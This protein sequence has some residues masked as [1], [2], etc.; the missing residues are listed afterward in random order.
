[1]SHEE[2]I[3]AQFLIGDRHPEQA[4]IIPS[5]YLFLSEN[6]NYFWILVSENYSDGKNPKSFK[7]KWDTSEENM[8]KD[9]LLMISL[10]VI[11]DKELLKNSQE[12]DPE[13]LKIMK[14]RKPSIGEI[15]DSWINPARRKKLYEECR[16]IKKWP[17]M[18]LSIFGATAFAV[19]LDELKNCPGIIEICMK[20]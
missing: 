7:V 20:R 9:A 12:Y 4:G 10:Y 5:H 17:R 8:L 2:T 3:T 16:S 18:I 14:D 15:D 6:H 19:H 1:M 11:K 13:L